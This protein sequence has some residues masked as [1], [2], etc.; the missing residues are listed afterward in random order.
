MQV[1]Q[2]PV[3]TKENPGTALSE[4]TMQ[5]WDGSKLFYRSWLPNKPYSKAIILFHGG[6]EHSGRFQDLVEQLDLADNAIFAWDARGH[7]RSPGIRGHANHFQDYV[8]DAEAFV[9]HISDKYAIPLK[10]MALIGHSVGSVIAATWV[11]DYAPPISSM[12]L[13]S[14]AFN[15]KLYIPAALPALKI[16]QRLKPDAHINSYVRPSMLTHDK[17]EAEARQSDPLI[18]PRISVRVLTSLFD[19]AERVIKSATGID[20]PTLIFSAGSDWVV[21]RSAHRRFLENLG[22]SEKTL[23]ELP[24]FY[25]E[26]FHE[27]DRHIPISEAREFILDHFNK[28]PTT[29]SKIGTTVKNMDQFKRLQMPL[30]PLALSYWKF[31]FTKLGLK[32]IGRLSQGVRLG[33]QSGFDSGRTLDYV[34]TN[35]ARGLGPI[36]RLIDRNYLNSAGWKGIRQ[37][38]IHLEEQLNTAITEMRDNGKKVHI[39]DM[40]GGPGRYLIE[41]LNRINDP[42]ISAVCRDKDIKGL[43]EGEKLA[44]QHCL[45]GLIHEQG[46]A[47]NENSIATLSPRPNIVIVSGLYELFHDNTMVLR[48]L[49]AIRKQILPGGRLIYTNQPHHPQL[50]MIARTLINRDGDPWVMRLR[51]QSE[52]NS[53]V[54][55]VGF[56]PQMMSV[57]DTG[58]FTVTTATLD[59]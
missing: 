28:K 52:M 58:I 5:T 17:A 25:H 37:R 30:S 16:V 54:Q 50:E 7:G 19:T 1:A 9:K 10:N 43:K 35:K 33:W 6:H 15:I 56:K 47:F 49:K 2:Q 3:N 34:Y 14:P 18:S 51:P 4:K 31:K 46:D 21:H 40:A 44:Q 32:T 57:D 24:G 42:N 13:G 8:R 39:V 20:V 22:T 23:R 55:Q 38:R 45:T 41:T 27:K 29:V 26:I 53:L 12:V 11:N 59:A 48:S 36:G